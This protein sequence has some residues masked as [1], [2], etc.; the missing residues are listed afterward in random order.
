MLLIFIQF[1]GLVNPFLSA[2]SNHSFILKAISL[3]I[4]CAL[5]V[6]A[7]GLMHLV[8]IFKTG[9]NSVIFVLMALGIQIKNLK[10]KRA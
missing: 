10:K 8:I 5:S 1:F 2:I 4:F 7:I 3:G 6:Q 9:L